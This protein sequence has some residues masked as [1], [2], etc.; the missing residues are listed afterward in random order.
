MLK[1]DTHAREAS[2]DS[3]LLPLLLAS[4]INFSRALKPCRNRVSWEDSKKN[5]PE[6]SQQAQLGESSALF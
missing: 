6:A 1:A 4:C 3:Q 5:V 2:G